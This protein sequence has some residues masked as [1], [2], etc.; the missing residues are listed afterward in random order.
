MRTLIRGLLARDVL[1]VTGGVAIALTSVAFMRA[2]V[3]AV[4][5]FVD[6]PYDSSGWT[7]YGPETEE[8]L[9]PYLPQSF[10]IDGRFFFYGDALRH[11][12][13]LVLTLL[14]VGVLLRGRRAADD[15]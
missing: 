12:I 11:G 7:A 15:R 6:S 1:A 8:L 10:V 9:A 14:L 4:V 2:L 13:V 3:A 5:D